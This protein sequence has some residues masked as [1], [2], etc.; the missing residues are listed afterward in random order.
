MGLCSAHFWNGRADSF[1]SYT[2]DKKEIV[3]LYLSFFFFSIEFIYSVDLHSFPNTR[4]VT[5]THQH[6]SQFAIAIPCTSRVPNKCCDLCSLKW[7]QT[8]SCGCFISFLGPFRKYF[9]SS[10][11]QHHDTDTNIPTAA[12]NLSLRLPVMQLCQHIPTTINKSGVGVFIYL[13]QEAILVTL[14]VLDTSGGSCL[15]RANEIRPLKSVLMNPLWPTL[16]LYYYR[17][18]RNAWNFH[19]R[20]RGSEDQIQIKWKC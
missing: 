4:K 12:T 19:K 18:S 16:W 14:T 5:T 9:A 17:L 13:K 1:E 10:F 8:H 20:Y 11:S 3:Y 6:V 15:L 7:R 2:L